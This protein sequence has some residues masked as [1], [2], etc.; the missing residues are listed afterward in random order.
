MNLIGD[1]EELEALAARYELRAAQVDQALQQLYAKFASAT[2]TCTK[3]D[4]WRAHV[5]RQR[6]EARAIATE[7]RAIAA[8]LRRSAAAV[9]NEL[10]VLHRLERA[11]RS[12]L[13][14]AV[15]SAADAAHHAIDLRDLP[16]SGDPSWRSIA[17]KLG[18]S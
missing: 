3:A 7:L 2:W 14:A 18:V 12:L 10:N 8:A 6:A 4:R 11:V 16:A 13:E 15:R 17:R 9:R 1:P 5:R